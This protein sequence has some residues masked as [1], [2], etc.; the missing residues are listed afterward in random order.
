M[1]YLAARKRLEDSANEENLVPLSEYGRN[2]HVSL[3]YPTTRS[4]IHVCL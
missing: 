1:E 3:L 2:C 4:L